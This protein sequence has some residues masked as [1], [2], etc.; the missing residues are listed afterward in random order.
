MSLI[1]GD[2]R[3]IPLRDGVVQTVVTS[4]PYWGLRDYGTARWEGGDPACDHKTGRNA[5]NDGNR[6]GEDGFAGNRNLEG[7]ADMGAIYFRVSCGRCGAKRIDAQLGLEPTPEE[8]VANMVA[9]FR[10]VRRVL[11]DDG[12]VWLNLGDSYATGT[13]KPSTNSPSVDVGYWR[14]QDGMGRRRIDGR[15]CGLKPKD[16]VGIPWMLAFALRADGWYL[17]SD[18]I[19]AK[20]NPMPESVTDRPTKAHEY[21][22]LLAKSERYFYDADAIREPHLGPP[23]S[24]GRSAHGYEERKWSDRTDGLARPPMTMRDREYNPAG[25]NRRSVW[26]INPQPYSGAHFATFPEK[27]V[28]PCILAGSRAGD[29]VCDPFIGSGTVGVV[30]TRLMRRWVGVDLSY[31]SLSRERTRQRGFALLQLEG[32]A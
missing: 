22:F 18:I 7:H 30:A 24:G 27:L 10:E 4:P 8:Y 17:R 32:T 16:L 3:Q 9:V 28:E 1:R 11:R 14:S 5:R 26:T 2:A 15:E 19:W 31:Q 23:P 6:N 13:S 12:T 21:I 25:R 29:L 20:P